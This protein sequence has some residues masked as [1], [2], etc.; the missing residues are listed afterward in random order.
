M[1]IQ[2]GSILICAHAF[3]WERR[4]DG[5]ACLT[6]H[7]GVEP[8]YRI[9]HVTRQELFRGGLTCLASTG[10]GPDYCP[11]L[12]ASVGVCHHHYAGVQTGN[13]IAQST[14]PE[15]QG[16]GNQAVPDGARTGTLARI[17][18]LEQGLIA[19][20]PAGVCHSVDHAPCP[21]AGIDQPAQAHLLEGHE[22]SARS[23]VLDRICYG[24]VSP[25]KPGGS[26]DAVTFYL[27]DHLTNIGTIRDLLVLCLAYIQ[28]HG[29]K[30]PPT[31]DCLATM[32]AFKVPCW[33]CN[34]YYLYKRLDL[35]SQR[36]N[37]DQPR[38]PSQTDMG[39]S[40][41]FRQLFGQQHQIVDARLINHP[42]TVATAR[43]PYHHR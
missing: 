9:D 24:R 21:A 25:G 26:P 35:L 14:R 8:H 30:S 23:G 38:D 36:A 28:P 37:D 2:T 22:R 7:S 4:I 32:A 17:Y 27:R 19:P 43:P 3:N 16:V 11:Q 13:G 39:I 31:E 10:G 41:N 15:G 5:C 18:P 42:A 34:L 40:V 12:Q 20:D 33:W 6:V 29:G 1:K